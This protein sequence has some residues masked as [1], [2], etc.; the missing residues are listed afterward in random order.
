MTALSGSGSGAARM[1]SGDTTADSSVPGGHA[2]WWGS[3]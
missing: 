2:S 3:C 1:S